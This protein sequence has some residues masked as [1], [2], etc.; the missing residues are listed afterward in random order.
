[1]ESKI[2]SLKKVSSE[3]IPDENN[4]KIKAYEGSGL[5][6]PSGIKKPS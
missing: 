5:K 3:T 6:I 1:M 2:P 4:S